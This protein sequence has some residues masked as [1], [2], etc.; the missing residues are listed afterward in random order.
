MGR[1]AGYMFWRSDRMGVWF[2]VFDFLKERLLQLRERASA[3]FGHYAPGLILFGGCPTT[4]YPKN[5]F[6]CVDPSTLLRL[7]QFMKVYLETDLDQI[8]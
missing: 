7:S 6:Q 8:E 4:G 3:L 5:N 1:G 2:R